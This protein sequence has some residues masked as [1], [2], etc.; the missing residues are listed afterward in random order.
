MN[1]VRQTIFFR[2][3]ILL[4]CML[5]A[6]AA[7]HAQLPPDIEAARLYKRLT[8]AQTKKEHADIAKLY[9]ALFHNTHFKP[10]AGDHFYYALSLYRAKRYEEAK[11][12]ITLYLTEHEPMDAQALDLYNDIE[13]NENGHDA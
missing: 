10:E 12:R 2:W 8:D 9:D 3:A 11:T 6:S 1:P 4:F 7:V 13:K 5:N